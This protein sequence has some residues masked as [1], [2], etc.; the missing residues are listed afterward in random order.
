[1]SDLQQTA[2]VLAGL[3]LQ[4]RSGTVGVT[5]SDPDGNVISFLK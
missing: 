3:G 5:V 1:V 2:R 4:V